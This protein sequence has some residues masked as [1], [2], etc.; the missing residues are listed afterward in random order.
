[1]PGQLNDT[2]GSCIT[3]PFAVVT[4]L[5]PKSASFSNASTASIGSPSNAPSPSTI[6]DRVMWASKEGNKCT[7][8]TSCLDSSAATSL[9]LKQQRF[10]PSDDARAN[11]RN[12][13]GSPAD[14]DAHARAQLTIPQRGSLH[15]AGLC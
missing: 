6:I 5:H 12:D 8:A 3:D 14:T 9:I 13:F 1:M 7:L 4:D 15:E 11:Q 2:A 10:T